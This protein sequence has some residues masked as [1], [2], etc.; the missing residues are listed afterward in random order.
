M[1]TL[2]D[3]KHQK[4]PPI[5]SELLAGEG[6]ALPIAEQGPGWLALLARDY[7]WRATADVINRGASGN[8]TRIVRA[9]LGELLAA[10]PVSRSADVRHVLVWLGATD[11]AAGQAHVA[12]P[13][14]AENL[15]AIVDV[16]KRALPDAG[17]TL[18][19]PPLPG[20]DVPA[21][22]H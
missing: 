18:L 20:E 2:E 12:V 13:E 6:S 4:S 10:L 19:T 3:V 7:A 17:I 9:D 11:C 21:P 14:F 22:Q 5:V 8:T 1:L 16:L 15:G